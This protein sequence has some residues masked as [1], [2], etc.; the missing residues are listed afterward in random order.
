MQ[1]SEYSFANTILKFWHFWMLRRWRLCIV[2]SVLRR[3]LVSL[4]RFQRLLGKYCLK[5]K[6]KFSPKRG[7]T[8]DKI[9]LSWITITKKVKNIM[10]MVVAC[11]FS[12]RRFSPCGAVSIKPV[13]TI[14]CYIYHFLTFRNYSLYPLRVFMCLFYL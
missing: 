6:E 8:N 1:R 9:Y 7:Y 4:G 13:I 5:M 10:A 11:C 3:C 12:F 2:S 14:S